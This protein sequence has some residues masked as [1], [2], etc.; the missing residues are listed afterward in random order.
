MNCS[1]ISELA[2]LY[3]TGELGVARAA[4]FDAHLKGC[5][6]CLRE[7]QRQARLDA[8][9]RDAVLSEEINA[10]NVDR[11]VRQLIAASGGVL[12]VDPKRSPRSHRWVMAALGVAALLLLVLG[13]YR[14]LLGTHVAKVYADA[15]RDHKFEVVDRQ[16]RKWSVHPDAL[17]ALA[18]K[19]GVPFLAVQALAS[20]NYKLERTKICYLDKHLYLHMVFLDGAQEFSVY[21]RPRDNQ[22]LAG[23]LREI[24]NGDPIYVSDSG[25]EHMASFETSQ[26]M[27]MIVTDQSRSA[28][29]D[30]AHFA[31]AV[32]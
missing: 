19:E 27:G 8:G 2:P 13:G 12:L 22:P 5:V 26:L 16:P 6:A 31:A 24:A 4:E 1:D 23:T 28:S 30:Y 20:G 25:N 32:L 18:A 3:I 7:L 11:R 29:L 10:T 14:A 15:A 9:L 21:L 17:A